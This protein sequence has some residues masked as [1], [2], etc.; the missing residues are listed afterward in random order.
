MSNPSRT[1]LI[2]LAALLSPLMA[3]SALGEEAEQEAQPAEAEALLQA[4][5]TPSPAQRVHPALPAL[6]TAMRSRVINEIH[7]SPEVRRAFAL[8][9]VS[10]RRNVQWFEGIELLEQAEALWSLQA[11]LVHPSED[12][13][14]HALRAL[15]RLGNERAVPFLLIYAHHMA[16]LE[17]GS[18]NATIHG[19]IH[20]TLAETVS[21]L[22]GVRIALDGQ[23]PQGLRR[24]I[25]MW[26]RA[27]LERSELGRED[28]PAAQPAGAAA[29]VGHP[30]EVAGDPPAQEPPPQDLAAVLDVPPEPVASAVM[31]GLRRDRFETAQEMFEALELLYRQFGSDAKVALHPV[32]KVGEDEEQE[33]G[34]LDEAAYLGLVSVHYEHEAEHDV[35]R[36]ARVLENNGMEP[37]GIGHS[38]R[39]SATVTV[40]V[41]Q[42]QIH[43]HGWKPDQYF[44]GTQLTQL[45][46]LSEIAG[47][48]ITSLALRSAGTDPWVHRQQIDQL[49]GRAREA[50]G[51]LEATLTVTDTERFSHTNIGTQGRWR[52][53]RIKA[54]SIELDFGGVTFGGV[55]GVG[56]E[57]VSPAGPG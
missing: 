54:R 25:R 49:L 21:T 1:T 6:P 55:F 4:A 17:V 14:I 30:A 12:V 23:D 16:V 35:D 19:I 45:E 34:R 24:G 36:A 11:C 29:K 2:L 43:N 13:Q 51:R 5:T 40:P 8:L 10:E 48:E 47:D 20:R 28:D 56:I 37:L 41:S 9:D 7:D 39:R 42:A 53:A 26:A 44:I 38:V 15:G 31:V 3:L 27:W 22:T 33:P 52:W 18:E 32:S 46:G 50:G 57:P